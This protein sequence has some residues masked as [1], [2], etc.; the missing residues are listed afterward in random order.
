MSHQPSPINTLESDIAS[1]KETTRKE[2]EQKNKGIMNLVQKINGLTSLL[3]YTCDQLKENKVEM[4]K[5]LETW[6]TNI[7]SVMRG[8]AD[9]ER[10]EEGKKTTL[11]TVRE[12]L[13][14]KLSDEEKEALGMKES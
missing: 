13:M 11:Q 8:S 1:I 10:K 7:L 3:C 2:N 6:H 4:N 12:R 14:A 5:D 9:T